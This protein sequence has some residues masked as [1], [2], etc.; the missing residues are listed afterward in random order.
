MG[1]WL[2]GTVTEAVLAAIM[3]GVFGLLDPIERDDLVDVGRAEGKPESINPGGRPAA[4]PAAGNQVAG[5]VAAGVA[6]IH[7]V[8]VEIGG[9]RRC[10]LQVDLAVIAGSPGARAG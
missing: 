8:V 9:R 2:T 5:F 4:D 7:G 3:A 6:A 1:D 10:P